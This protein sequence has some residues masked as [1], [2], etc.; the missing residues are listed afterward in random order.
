MVFAGVHEGRIFG[1]VPPHVDR[2][3]APGASVMPTVTPLGWLA[4]AP[5]A[6]W[7]TPNTVWFA[8][9]V[10]MYVGMPYDLSPAGAA[11]A[12]PLSWRFFALRAP[13][14]S[15][16]VFGYYGYWHLTLHVLGWAGRPLVR[17]R[18]YSADKVAHNV[19]W[20]SCGVALWVAFENVFAFLWA[21]GRLPYLADGAATAT[22][23]GLARL[24]LGVAL[25]PIWR[26]FHFYWAHRLLHMR[27]LYAQVHSLHHRN[28]D[29]EPFAGLCMHP[30]E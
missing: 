14:W 12:S 6:L 17:G 26:E 15:A 18:V 16:V 21:S 29:I 30:V 7:D 19:W 9:A 4:A 1:S 25:V 8:I 10:A 5:T 20:T 28:T 24:V 2:K 27:S 23:A 22:P 3:L 13:L 11:A